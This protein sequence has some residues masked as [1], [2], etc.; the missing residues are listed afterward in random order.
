MLYNQCYPVE[1]CLRT[2]YLLYN[3]V[4][5]SRSRLFSSSDVANM[6]KELRFWF[7]ILWGPQQLWAVYKLAENKLK[8]SPSIFNCTAP[9]TIGYH[10]EKNNLTITQVFINFYVN[11]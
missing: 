11:E 6:G 5:P 7:L 8:I 4:A 9:M 3:K 1:I 2:E 10:N